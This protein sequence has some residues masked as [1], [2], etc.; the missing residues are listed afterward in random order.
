MRKFSNIDNEFALKH[1]LNLS[2]VY[3]YEWILNLPKWS[4]SVIIE[5]KIYYYAS[6][7]KACV[8]MP[9]VTNKRNTMHKHY[10]FLEKN[11]FVIITKIEG[12]DYIHI[13][14]LSKEWNTSN[15]LEKNPTLFGK[16]SKSELEKNPTDSN[17]TYNSNVNIDFTNLL[18]FIIEKTGRN[19]RTINKNIQQ[20]YKAR[21][22]DGYKKEDIFNAIIN[23]S[24]VQT[25]KDNGG[26]YLTPEFF[27]RSST[28][29]KYGFPTATTKKGQI[30]VS[31]KMKQGEFVNF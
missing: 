5:N 24:N 10:K 16:K 1:N 21:L 20:K 7:N 26:Q 23:A 8:D 9:I 18:N 17:I 3:V 2:Q 31:E 22:R 13:T 27:S 25:H 19:Y 14:E 30:E 29:D 12:K 15:Y 6:K 28:L 4:N 11:G